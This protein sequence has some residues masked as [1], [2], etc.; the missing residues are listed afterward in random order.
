MQP[1]DECMICL[2]SLQAFLSCTSKTENM[3]QTIYTIYFF[4]S[5]TNQ[6]FKKDESN[7]WVFTS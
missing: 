1:V 3:H 6:T 2:A 7:W 4:V 5:A